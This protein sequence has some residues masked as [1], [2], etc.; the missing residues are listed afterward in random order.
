MVIIF[1]DLSTFYGFHWEIKGAILTDLYVTSFFFSPRRK[2]F[3][4]AYIHVCIGDKI[5]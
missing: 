3:T 1:I 5:T 2:K 4:S